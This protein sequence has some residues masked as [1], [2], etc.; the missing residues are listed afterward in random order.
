MVCNEGP[1]PILKLGAVKHNPRWSGRGRAGMLVTF[2]S[3]PHDR[4]P[5]A[6]RVS[7]QSEHGCGGSYRAPVIHI[8]A[9]FA[10]PLRLIAA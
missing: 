5:S 8:D 10:L 1:S 3:F 6:G 9:S 7:L 4:H 2:K